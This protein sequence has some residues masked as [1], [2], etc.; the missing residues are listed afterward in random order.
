M[1]EDLDLRLKI[2]NF[3]KDIS[4]N[5]QF[6]NFT[7]SNPTFVR[8]NSKNLSLYRK[9][10]LKKNGNDTK[11][12]FYQLYSLNSSNVLNEESKLDNGKLFYYLIFKNFVINNMIHINTL[13]KNEENE[14]EK[15]Y[16]LEYNIFSKWRYM[17]KNFLIKKLITYYTIKTHK[18][19]S[20]CIYN[21]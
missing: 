6:K 17:I 10:F 16:I 8:G 9:E 7:F 14:E 11:F 18:Y 20:R 13:Y 19:Y 5:T 12:S 3:F 2:F 15:K 1:E 21:Q 4:N